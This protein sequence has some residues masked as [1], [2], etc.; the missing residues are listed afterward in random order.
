MKRKFHDILKQHASLDLHHAEK[1]YDTF[2]F[3]CLFAFPSS[4]EKIELHSENGK[5]QKF[6]L[7]EILRAPWNFDIFWSSRKNVHHSKERK[8]ENIDIL[9]GWVQRPWGFCFFSKFSLFF[10]V[11]LFVYF[12]I[13]GNITQKREKVEIQYKK[14]TR[15][16]KV[17]IQKTKNRWVYCFS[18][19]LVVV[20]LLSDVFG[21]RISFSFFVAH[22]FFLGKIYLGFVLKKGR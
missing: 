7:S 10:F 3:R 8:C 20:I 19:S 14:K 15:S 13:L 22:F 18:P 1:N 11:C 5:C 2:L 9:L 6:L 12:L 21:S 16:Q 4:E 17:E